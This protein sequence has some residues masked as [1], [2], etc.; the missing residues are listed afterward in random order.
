MPYE[1][2]WIVEGHILLAIYTTPVTLDIIAEATKKM[3]KM[4]DESTAKIYIISDFSNAK[5]PAAANNHMD[6]FM[7]FGKHVNRG[8]LAMVGVSPLLAFALK[9]GRRVLGEILTFNSV[10]EAT[11]FLIDASRARGDYFELPPN[12]V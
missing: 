11:K 6:T 8:I 3:T 10:S 2:R 1:I 12:I 5:F 7:A 9:L 4:M